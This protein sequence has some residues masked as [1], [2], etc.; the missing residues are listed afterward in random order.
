MLACPGGMLQPWPGCPG[1]MGT[2]EA[3]LEFCLS[4]ALGVLLRKSRQLVGIWPPAQLSG[5]S[6][7]EGRCL[8]CPAVGLC[9]LSLAAVGSR[10]KQGQSAWEVAVWKNLM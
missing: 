3:F 2:Q 6:Y 7:R 9:G 10:Y 8:L 4:P 5:L 1:G